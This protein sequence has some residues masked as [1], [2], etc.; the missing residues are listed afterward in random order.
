MLKKARMIKKGNLD[1]NV[2][3]GTLIETLIV[4][5]EDLVQVVAKAG[6]LC[7]PRFSSL[8]VMGETSSTDKCLPTSRE[9]FYLLMEWQDM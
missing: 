5:S 9:L 6:C 7:F 3:N 2:L 1:A 8:Y 4:H